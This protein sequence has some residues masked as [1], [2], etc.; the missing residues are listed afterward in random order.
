MEK[1]Y[2][3]NFEKHA[4]DFNYVCDILFNR[5]YDLRMAG[6]DEQADRLEEKRD[7][8][9]D[10]VGRMVKTSRAHNGV[11]RLFWYRGEDYAFLRNVIEFAHDARARAIAMFACER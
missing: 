11:D 5:A 4:H 6:K 9:W 7:K 1:A 2:P 3:I 8:I 10:T